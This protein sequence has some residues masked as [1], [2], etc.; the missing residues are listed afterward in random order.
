MA[1]SSDHDLVILGIAG[2]LRRDSFNR[3]LVRAAGEIA[4]ELSEGGR[5]VR[6]EA[7]PLD[8]IPLYNKDVED[9]GFPDGVQ[10]LHQA[11]DDADAVL[12]AT[13]EYQF[14]VP[15]VLKNAI[16]WASR[17]PGESTLERKPVAIM[18]AT[19]GM[20]GTARAQMQLRQALI[21]NSCPMVLQPEVLV[22]KA[23]DRF[24]DDGNLTHG[25]TR[26]FV[27]ELLEGLI[28]LVEG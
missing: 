3:R 11:I 5:S 12:I 8:D 21:Y 4:G 20:W 1:S 7:F 9:E 15:G 19:P 10:A 22:A 25:P 16:D 26:N 18:G 17:P 6:V 28:E 14:G 13:P 23:G 2:S 27:R 24:D